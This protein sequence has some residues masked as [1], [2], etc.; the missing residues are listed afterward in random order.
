MAVSIASPS[1]PMVIMP[2]MILS[3]QKNSRASRMR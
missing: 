3:D 1:R 2:A